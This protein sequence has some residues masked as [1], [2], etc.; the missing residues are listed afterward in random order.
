MAKEN[1]VNIRDTLKSQ[2]QKFA[3]APLASATEGLFSALGYQ[4]D[5]QMR[6]S[7]VQEFREG[8]DE[9]KY[10]D[11][12]KAYIKNWKSIGL[13]MQLTD[14]EIA[15]KITSFK[16]TEVQPIILQS[17]IFLSIELD[18]QDQQYTRTQLAGITRQINR[19]FATPVLILFKVGAALS[20]AVM[21]RR[22]NKRDENK[23]VLGKVTLIQNIN[24]KNPHIGHLDILASFALSELHTTQRP[25]NSFETLHKAWEEVFNVELLNKKFYEELSNWYFWA[26]RA[27]NV[28]FPSDLEPDEATR[29]STSVIRLLTRLIFCWFLKEKGLISETVF[30]A[31]EIQKHLK[32]F[33][34]EESTYYHAILQNLFFAT[35]NQP[36]DE[37]RFAIDGS[38]QENRNEYGIKSVYR[39]SALF[40]D[41]EKSVKELFDDVPFLNG[42]LFACLDV[43]DKQGKVQYADGFS[44]NPKKQ[45][46]V[47]NKLFFAQDMTIDL[48]GKEDFG[49]PKKKKARVRGLFSILNSYKF[50]VTEST[51]IE[52]E[53]ALD[54]ELLGNVFENLLASYNPETGEN[55]RRQTGSFYTP[56][57]IVDYMVDQTLKAYLHDSV[58]QKLSEMDSK[59]VKEKIDILFAYT[60]K[61]HTFTEK[62]SEIL[63]EAINACNILDPACGSGAYPMGI[64]HKLV[65]IL[66]KLDPNNQKWK[67]SQLDK[68]EDIA[69]STAR[70]NA[71]EAIEQAFKENAFDYGR[72]L[73]LIENC[74]YGVDIQPIAI[75]ISKL[76]FFISL[77]CE[78]KV[79]VSHNQKKNRGIR[80]LP[81]L[82]TKFIAANTLVKLRE[83][84]LDLLS[85][86][87]QKLEMQLE[88]VRR[89][90]FSA[91]TRQEKK[92]L[93]EQD[94]EITER[95]V[96]LLIANKAKNND[97]KRSVAWNPY[98]QH[99]VAGFF[100]PTVMFGASLKDGFDII[101]G[102]PPYVQIQKFSE[103]QKKIWEDQK[104]FVFSRTADIYCL[105]YER[106]A[107][108]LKNG[109][110][111][112]YI[113]S[114]KWMRAAY[115]K[116]L[117]QFFCLQVSTEELIDF[118]GILVFNDATVDTAIVHF[119]KKTSQD[120]F[121]AIVLSQ[122]LSMDQN[123]GEYIRKN[124][125]DFRR[126]LVPTDPWVVSSSARKE[127]IK[128]EVEEQGKLLQ[129]WQIMI[130]R[131]ILTGLNDAFYI[132][133]EMRDTLISEDQK[134]E[135]LI[136]PLLRGRDIE[137]YTTKWDSIKDEKWMINVH[138]G[139][140]EKNIPPINAEKDYPAIW[141]H[142]QQFQTLLEPRLDQ[143]DHW[144][145]LR[146]CAYLEDFK[147]PKI[148]YPN[149]T[150]Y[151]PFYLDY[152]KHFYGNQK[153]FIITSESESLAYLTAMFNSNLFRYCFSN[154]FPNLGE[155][156]RELGKVF[157]E[158]IP[159][160][161][162]NK[163]QEKLFG[164]LV[165][166]VQ[167]A[168][169][170]QQIHRHQNLDVVADFLVNVIDACVL[171][172]YFTEHMAEK[173]LS[174]SQHVA[175]LLP[176]KIAAMDENQCADA[177][178]Q[179]FAIANESKH[180]IRNILLRI[181]LDSPDLLGVIQQEG[182]VD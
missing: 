122:S 142:L 170:K 156:R 77:V 25:V 21:N 123:L 62:E 166:L 71:K 162:P 102:N 82:E 108:L 128:K 19:V 158:K 69:D 93:R 75:Q 46:R 99:S 164:A 179:F 88:K 13:L 159:I 35:L 67:Q 83:N 112:S 152:N 109:G 120:T 101:I 124:K 4:S 92:A 47:P 125:T 30:H 157:M 147:K 27:E 105:F 168:K 68:A 9:H 70:K 133:S 136:V 167:A 6:V 73:Y 43:E 91:Q 8:F 103:E 117:R 110:H 12:E 95:L 31:E 140:R 5:R 33:S 59:T 57:P 111:L 134:S 38:F 56:R 39:Y 127:K 150:K 40:V 89:R 65:F 181:P 45:P 54:P 143:G 94:E 139:V 146:N 80:A 178:V 63:I 50:T 15:K 24:V 129:N 144:S 48:S 116:N 106:G 121:P 104:Y 16:V 23:D 176:E 141:Q 3:T 130:N 37:R 90:Y 78:Q 114:N 96:G 161:K 52:Q 163:E 107:R 132:S 17:Y 60:E 14:E 36:M 64:L 74:I 135:D 49:D 79:D 42:G 81:N 61:S 34:L 153:C 20:L 22:Q 173:K 29:N 126:P 154:N 98:D 44:R 169:E 131:G 165:P 7:S 84:N 85:I 151:L 180:P 177:A 10:L 26:R 58:V 115:G 149:M 145:N 72:K 174:I 53:I 97:I 171:E 137:R 76:R 2:I 160:K 1:K 86:D 66:A 119:S 87:A 113:T 118:G 148:I 55:A 155:D 18:A 138:N 175:A 100:E 182:K 11:H 41:A 51:P 172:V 28:S 32:S